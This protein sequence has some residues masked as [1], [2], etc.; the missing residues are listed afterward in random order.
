VKDKRFH[1]IV[2]SI[3]F[4]CLAWLSVNLR[5]DYI[6]VRQMPVVLENLKE[7]KSLKYPIPK[8]ITVRFKGNGWLITGLYLFTDVKYYIDLSSLGS[9][10]FAITSR[11]ALEH[12]KLPFAVQIVDVTPDTL[13]L[14]LDEYFEKR[15]PVIPRIIVNYHEGYG[16]VG[17]IQMTPDSVSIG[18]AKEYLEHV[19][20]W[21][22][23]YQKF[24][25]Q[26]TSIDITV[27]LEDP[28]NFSLNLLQPF[29]HLHVTVQPFA[30][31]TFSGI[32]M[33]ATMTPTN[34]EVI[35]IPPKMDIIVRGG[36]DQLAKLTNNDFDATI[37]YESL[38]NNPDAV[39]KPSLS[40]PTGVKIVRRKPDLFQFIIRK[41]L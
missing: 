25:D 1:I 34:R 20:A 33:T 35:F 39:V 37:S 24:S 5:E 29:A 12:I 14:A 2:A 26:R 36:I 41:R 21:H 38:I 28:D 27:P 15:V 13:L 23:T 40:A 16:Q 19:T 6:V 3:L 4:A 9:G 31:K 18:G 32:S 10:T 30:E 22:S 8:H 7:G 17:D 11:D